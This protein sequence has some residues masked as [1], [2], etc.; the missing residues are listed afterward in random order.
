MT[1]SSTVG[2]INVMKMKGGKLWFVPI[3]LTAA[4]VAVKNVGVHTVGLAKR[5]TNA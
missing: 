4:I 3:C 5:V 2:I 1:A